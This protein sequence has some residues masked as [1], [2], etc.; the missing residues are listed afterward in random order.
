[1]E[2]KR[3]RVFISYHHSIDQKYK[4][5]LVRQNQT[6]NLFENLSVNEKGIDDAGLSAEQVRRIIRDD[7]MQE[8]TVLVVLCGQETK[9]RKHIDW[10]IH[11]AMYDSE[12]N[13]QMG[14][15]VVNL[16]TIGQTVERSGYKESQ[17][18]FRPTTWVTANNERRALETQF[19][20]MPSRILDNFESNGNG[21]TVINWNTFENNIRN[22]MGVIDVAF[23]HRKDKAYNHSAPLRRNNS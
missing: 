17:Q 9:N 2:I 6:H 8:A 12:V 1:M 13:P 14:I 19:P 15:V 4:D 5:W 10:E 20:Y 21:I 23:R 18:Y 7:Y 3:H 11:T 22:L 16:P